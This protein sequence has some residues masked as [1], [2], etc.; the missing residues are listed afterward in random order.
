LATFHP[1]SSVAGR[2]RGLGF[3]LQENWLYFFTLFSPVA[4]RRFHCQLLLLNRNVANYNHFIPL[5]LS[6]LQ[7]CEF[8]ANWPQFQSLDLQVFM[9]TYT[10]RF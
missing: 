5:C 7:K 6:T 8:M 3:N 10:S 1:P 2:A 4:I 9:T